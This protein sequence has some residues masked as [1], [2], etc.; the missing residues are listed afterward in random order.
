MAPGNRSS[1]LAEPC[2]RVLF[3]YSPGRRSFSSADSL[4]RLS[5]VQQHQQLVHLEDAMNGGWSASVEG[6]VQ[7][8]QGNNP[9]GAAERGAQGGSS[10][11]S[12][13][14]L[15]PE[16]VARS[17]DEQYGASGSSTPSRGPPTPGE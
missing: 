11:A 4:G 5:D 6:D 10:A 17:G 16:E 15:Q 3:R 9:G 1:N 7:G 12:L 2:S 14:L 8:F 13:Q